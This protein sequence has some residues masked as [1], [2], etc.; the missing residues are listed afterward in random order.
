M[1]NLYKDI[2][3]NADWTYT[4]ECEN[5]GEPVPLEVDKESPSFARILRGHCQNCHL[6][7]ELQKEAYFKWKRKY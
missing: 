3:P 6:E 2:Y 1:K 7:I 4:Y 5:C